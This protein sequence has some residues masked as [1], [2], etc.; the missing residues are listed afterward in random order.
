[1]HQRHSDEREHA[2]A[3]QDDHEEKTATTAI[4]FGERPYRAK[5]EFRE[6]WIRLLFH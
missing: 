5:P 1:M 6:E 2:H 4:G 3:E